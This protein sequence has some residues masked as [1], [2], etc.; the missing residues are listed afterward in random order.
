MLTFS[1]RQPL[2]PSTVNLSECLK[3]FRNVLTATATGN[4]QL[5]IA[6]PADLWPVRI[7]VNEFEVATI[8]LLVNARDALSQGGFVQISGRN[9]TVRKND[10]PVILEGDFVVIEVADNGVGIAANVIPRIFDPFFSTKETGKGTGLGLSQVHGFARQAGGAV[11][12]SSKVGVER[13]SRFICRA[14][15]EP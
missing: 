2:N 3:R 7:D 4:I 13:R 14:P 15:T 6:V 1:R 10:E 8:N 12:V 11:T 5:D 9:V